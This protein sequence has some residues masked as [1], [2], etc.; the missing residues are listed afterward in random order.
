MKAYVKVILVVSMVI[1]TILAVA[2]VQGESAGHPVDFWLLDHQ[3]DWNGEWDYAYA[4]K[5][6][7][8]CWLM[9]FCACLF[10]GAS[11]LLIGQG[12]PMLGRLVTQSPRGIRTPIT[13][14]GALITLTIFW[15]ISCWHRGEALIAAVRQKDLRQVQSILENA[16]ISG[17]NA[18]YVDTALM[19]A[20]RSGCTDVAKLLVGK[21]ADVNAKDSD[22]ATALM[23]AS[24]SGRIDG[25]KLLVDKGA[26]VNAKGPHCTTALIGAATNGHLECV[27]L[28]LEKGADLNARDRARLT[29][30]QWALK[31]GHGE[32]AEFLKA[33]GAKE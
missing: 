26:E 17:P 24:R 31:R 14:A 13:V 20:C 1:A 15:S 22:G 21:G 32:I 19:E 27:K 33:R 12:L 5:L 28:L 29:A 4:G 3:C 6:F 30:L 11:P 2:F 23:E 9:S 16:D 18:K 8:V 10:I 7:S 25:V